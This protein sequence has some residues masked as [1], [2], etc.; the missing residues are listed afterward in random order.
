VKLSKLVC[1]CRKWSF[2]Q[3]LRRWR[4]VI[5]LSTVSTRRRL[6]SLVFSV[7][8][9]LFHAPLISRR[10]DNGTF[11]VELW[12]FHPPITSVLNYS[13]FTYRLPHA[14]TTMARSVVNFGRLTH[15][16]LYS[17]NLAKKAR[18][19]AQLCKH[20]GAAV[21][22]SFARPCESRWALLLR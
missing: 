14:E 9:W 15:R 4:F 12:L 20:R 2:D 1:T 17:N 5:C 8:L 6:K 13:C 3:Q 16:W 19:A 22:E 7:Q 18:C 21:G 10:E 11:S